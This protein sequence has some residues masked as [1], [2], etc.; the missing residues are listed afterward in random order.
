M[1]PQVHALIRYLGQL[2][3]AFVVVIFVAV[4][5]SILGLTLYVKGPQIL[6]YVFAGPTYLFF[7]LVGSV[8]G[9]VVNRRQRS[10]V[11]P[12][13]WVLAT[14]GSAYGAAGDLSGGIHKGE[15]LSGYIWNTLILGNHE[16]ALISQWVVGAPVL[17]SL[18][19][20]FGAWI[21][22]RRP[23]SPNHCV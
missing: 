3:V 7:I 13:I 20:S 6:L 17:T 14:L 21:A 18:A 4:V 9:Y 16:L 2:F 19:Y 8:L 15:S 1:Q 10:R 12:W 22:I 5:G 23:L 11:A